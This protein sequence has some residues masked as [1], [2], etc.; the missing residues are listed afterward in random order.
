MNSFIKT[1]A[2]GWFA[3]V[4]GTAVSSLALTLLAQRF[5]PLPLQ[6]SA[7]IFFTGQQSA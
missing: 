7:Q 2:P 4:M 5:P 1:M 6:C 3:S